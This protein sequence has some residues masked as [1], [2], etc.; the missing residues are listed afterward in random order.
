M[1]Q[2]GHRRASGS[3]SCHVAA[4]LPNWGAVV[5]SLDWGITATALLD[6]GATDV[7]T[8]DLGTAAAAHPEQGATVVAPTDRGTFTATAHRAVVKRTLEATDTTRS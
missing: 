8:L 5:T 4:V 3:G 1:S 7:V 6:R 2:G